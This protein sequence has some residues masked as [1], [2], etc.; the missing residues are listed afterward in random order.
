MSTSGTSLRDKQI[1]EFVS[2]MQKVG[3][4]LIVYKADVDN[5]QITDL[6]ADVCIMNSQ[7]AHD[8]YSGCWWGGEFFEWIIPSTGKEVTNISPE[9]MYHGMLDSSE[10]GHYFFIITTKTKGIMLNTYGGVHK[11]TIIHMSLNHMNKLLNSVRSLDINAY[12]ELFGVETA[13]DSIAEM[14]QFKI[15]EAVNKLPT[16]DD[17]IARTQLLYER[18]KDPKDKSNLLVIESTIHNSTYSV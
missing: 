13:F 8:I 5:R 16:K 2:L 17:L 15:T 9:G 18:E 4:E 12:R 11:L 3:Y 7:D 1:A 10:E 6:D 14:Y